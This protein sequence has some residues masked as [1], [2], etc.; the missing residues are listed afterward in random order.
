MDLPDR[1]RDPALARRIALIAQSH[2]RLLGAPLV[3]EGEDLAEALWNAPQVIL[4]HGTEADPLFY[5]ANRAALARFDARLD[6]IIGMPSR[7]SAE[8]PNRAERQAL[9][10]RVS[11]DGFIADYSGVRISLTGQRFRIEQA[12]VWNLIGADGGV[13]GQ[14]ASF[15]CWTEL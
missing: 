11:R 10:D 14:A 12:T 9:L 8:A 5:F 13:C 6:Q 7:L 1:F 15:R 4:A 3:A 2:A